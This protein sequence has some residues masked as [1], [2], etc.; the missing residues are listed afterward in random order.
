M[1]ES[2]QRDSLGN[3]ASSGQPP[4]SLVL[5]WNILARPGDSP[6]SRSGS[7]PTGRAR[8]S[9]S[10]IAGGRTSSARA[11]RSGTS[12]TA[13]GTQCSESTSTASSPPARGVHE[14]SEAAR[15]T[16]RRRSLVT[17]TEA[18]TAMLHRASAPAG[19]ARDAR[20]TTPWYAALPT[21]AMTRGPAR[22]RFSRAARASRRS[23]RREGRS[24][25]ASSGEP[26]SSGR[27]RTRG[28]RGT[29][30]ARAVAA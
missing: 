24:I 20:E 8:G 26:R 18:R 13:A 15:P 27:S 14:T 5:A 22:R 29:R 1:A 25:R 11:S 28:A 9:S 16:G 6:R 10:S 2:G 17:S 7:F 19:R 12:T 21:N 30:A 4:S 23:R 3:G